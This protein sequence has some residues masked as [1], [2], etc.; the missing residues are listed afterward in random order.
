MKRS[1]VKLVARCL[2]GVVFFAQMT[3]AAYA[4]PGWPS[5]LAAGAKFDQ[6]A[7]TATGSAAVAPRVESISASGISVMA[8]QM[9]GCSDMAGAMDFDSANLCA[10]HCKYGQQ[11]D[12]APTLSLPAVLLSALYTTPAVPELPLPPGVAALTDAHAAA[13]L[14]HAILHCVFRI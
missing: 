6:T 9:P 1:L 8:A 10:E 2:V 11:S 12:H 7:Q 13:A 4:C 3:I 5:V 14:P